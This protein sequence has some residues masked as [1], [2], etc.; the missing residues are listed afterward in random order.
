GL[1]YA[2]TPAILIGTVHSNNGIAIQN[3]SFNGFAN[4][5]VTYPNLLSSIPSTGRLPVNILEVEPDYQLGR[6]QQFSFN[7][8]GRVAG[9][10]VTV[11]YLGVRA[12]QLTRSRD[13]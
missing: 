2:R 12:G 5:P 9:A 7:V 11:G 4:I 6:T 3:Y 13:I 10:A 8:E 1:F